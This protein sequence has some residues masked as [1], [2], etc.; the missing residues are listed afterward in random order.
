VTDNPD[1]SNESEN[2]GHSI[3]TSIGNGIDPEFMTHS[4]YV[5]DTEIDE[6]LDGEIL[7]VLLSARIECEYSLNEEEIEYQEDLDIHVSLIISDP[8][9]GR[10]IEQPYSKGVVFGDI[11]QGDL[12]AVQCRFQ[13]LQDGETR[14]EAFSYT[15]ILSDENIF[16]N[17]GQIPNISL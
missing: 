2:V 15:S 8:E 7:Y 13:I 1:L 14:D 9:S 16:I 6:G 3:S 12:T 17:Q 4:L 11:I 5:D 10:F